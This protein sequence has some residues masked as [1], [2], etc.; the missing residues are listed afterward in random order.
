MLLLNLTLKC[1]IIKHSN[2]HTYTNL[3]IV[4]EITALSYSAALIIATI[5][6]S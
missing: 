3:A 5:S 6:S 1:V 2:H 4:K